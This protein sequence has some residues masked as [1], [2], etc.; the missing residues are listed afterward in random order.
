M[1]SRAAAVG[2]TFGCLSL[3]YGTNPHDH[4]QLPR[5]RK[6]F[7]RRIILLPSWLNS[8]SRIFRSFFEGSPSFSDLARHRLPTLQHSLVVTNP[9]TA[10]T[11]SQV[12]PPQEW[13]LSL[14]TRPPHSR[15]RPSPRLPP[16]PSQVGLES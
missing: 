16:C 5:P 13:K 1:S 7:H 14:H 2:E 6:Y 8:R 15:L 12:A 4:S 3:A 10:I 9:P 11:S